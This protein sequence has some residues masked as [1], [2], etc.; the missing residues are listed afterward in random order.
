MHWRDA[1]APPPP[2]GGILFSPSVTPGELAGSSWAADVTLQLKL[3]LN[4][5]DTPAMGKNLQPQLA[6]PLP[7]ILG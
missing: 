4:L 2:N 6:Q 3:L 5:I 7:Q 1:I